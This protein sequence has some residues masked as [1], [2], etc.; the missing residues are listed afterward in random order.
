VLVLGQVPALSQALRQ[1]L[2]LG[3]AL[4]QALGP[5]SGQVPATCPVSKCL[6]SLSFRMPF[7]TYAAKKYWRHEQIGQCNAPQL[8][9]YLLL[10]ASVRAPSRWPGR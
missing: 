7:T 8:A 3:Q 9:Q 6:A 4:R 1:V 2:V 5:A 10:A